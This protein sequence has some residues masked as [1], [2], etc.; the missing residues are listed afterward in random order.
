MDHMWN[1]QCSVLSA[2]LDN[3]CKKESQGTMGGSLFFGIGVFDNTYTVP[4]VIL[5]MKG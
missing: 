1:C 4:V 3:D 2:R 5:E